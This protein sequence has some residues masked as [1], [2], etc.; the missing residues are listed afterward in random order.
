MEHF[1]SDPMT[2]YNEGSRDEYG[3]ESYSAG[4]SVSGRFI[5]KNKLIYS[6]TGESIQ[7]DALV[8]LPSS[9]V[10]SIGSKIL[11]ED[12]YYRVVNIHKPKGFSNDERFIKCYLVIWSQ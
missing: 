8:H 12:G 10:I 3:R 11:Y 5:H 9:T 1:F 6:P 4:V 7:S 2:V